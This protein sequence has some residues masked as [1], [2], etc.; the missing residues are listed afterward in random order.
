M[1]GYLAT[2]LSFFLLG[3]MFERF[4]V[5]INGQP[6]T[7]NKVFFLSDKENR[8]VQNSKNEIKVQIPKLTS[9]SENN[10]AKILE[11]A[12]NFKDLLYDEVSR[13][14][15]STSRSIN[16]KFPNERIENKFRS[17]NLDGDEKEI[18]FKTII[19]HNPITYVE[20]TFF[21]KAFYCGDWAKDQKAKVDFGM[22]KCIDV[23]G[24]SKI[25]DKWFVT[26]AG[27]TLYSLVYKNENAFFEITTT[28]SLNFFSTS[29]IARIM[30]PIPGEQTRSEALFV[31]NN[32][33]QWD[34]GDNVEYVLSSKKEADA[35]LEKVI[36]ENPDK[37]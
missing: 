9:P 27:G 37:L 33:L 8:R 10:F 35:F 1:R 12:E 25:I 22:T 28:N 26:N 15:K 18:W 14:F 7:R 5:S 29:G 17:W 3:V 6:P 24:F 21:V 11:N 23:L 20:F 13:N 4:V 32:K 19:A 34:D 30:L 36:K 31:N 16:K 2:A